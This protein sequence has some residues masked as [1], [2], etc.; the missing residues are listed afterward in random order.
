MAAEARPVELLRRNAPPSPAMKRTRVIAG[1][2]ALKMHRLRAAETG[3]VNLEIVS[4]PQLA[5]RLA[6]GFSRPASPIEVLPAIRASLQRGGFASIQG[7]A[8]LPGM[9]RAV[10]QTLNASW[11]TDLRLKSHAATRLTDLARID[12]DVRSSLPSGALAPPD[13]RDAALGRVRHVRRLFGQIELVDLLD[14]DPVWRPL[15][16][17]IC[18]ETSVNWQLPREAGDLNWFP[19]TVHTNAKAGAAEPTPVIC[20]DPRSEVVEALRWVRALL[21][22][23]VPPREIGIAALS[24]EPWDKFMLVLARSAS[25]PV[26]FTHGLSALQGRDGQACSALADILLRGLSQVRVRRLLDRAPKARDGLPSD[27]SKGLKRAAGLFTVAQW[28]TALEAARDLRESGDAAELILLERLALL[29]HGP[30]V[31]AEAGETFLQT[32]ALDLWREALRAEPPQALDI[33]LARLNV[34]D[35]LSPGSAVSWGPAWHLSAAPRPYVRLLGLTGRSWPRTRTEDPLLPDHVIPRELI[36]GISRPEQDERVFRAIARGATAT[37]I[38]SRSRRSSE[39]APLAPSRLFPAHGARI[40]SAVRIPEHAFSESDRLLARPQEALEQPQLALGRTC[41]RNWWSPNY[42]AHDGRV[43]PQD[44]IIRAALDRLQSAT[45]GR[46]LLRDPLGFVW[47]SALGWSPAENHVDVLALDRPAFGQLIHELLRLTIETL[48][49]GPGLNRASEAEIHEA[50]Q[51][52]ADGVLKV[53]PSERPVPPPLLWRRT[54]DEGMRVARDALLLDEGLQ[55]GTRSWSEVPFGEQG[56]QNGPWETEG[57]VRL[58]GL[59]FGGRIDRLDIRGDQTAARVTDYKSGAA[60]RNMDRV[61]IGGGA[62]LQR[63]IYAAAV[64]QG[65]PEVRQVVSRLV[66]LWDG[67]VQHGLTGQ[68]LEDA[69]A[70]TERFIATAQAQLMTG[71]A[72]PGPDVEDRFNEMRL[73]LPAELELYMR[74]KAAARARA[75]SELQFFWNRP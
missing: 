34:P 13:L 11:R 27:W 21:A 35:P 40:L 15:L 60:P 5:A 54:V 47:R 41:W 29:A 37:F 6:G 73:A 10:D 14:I 43:P 63:V 71:S 30:E 51:A 72:P 49:N 57:P 66:Y 28:A 56:N 23:G 26:H 67:P 4:L 48:E 22:E 19:G 42:T 58:G 25:L 24:P 68:R 74:R 33:S 59:T 2:L 52:A 8:N 75:S 70:E 64:Q 61:V 45:S 20:A 1:P 36:E 39:G 53:W 18:Q 62:E 50:V 12:S 44:P 55:P 16:A 38:I 31:A 32:G 65:L 17:A 9:V 7:V 46:R 69:I 3:A